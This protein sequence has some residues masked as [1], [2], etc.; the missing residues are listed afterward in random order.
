MSRPRTE[1][2]GRVS[3]NVRLPRDLY[4]ELHAA[5]DEREVSVNRIVTR[6]VRVWLDSHREATP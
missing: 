6:A 5:A 2:E 4:Q 3:I 1:P